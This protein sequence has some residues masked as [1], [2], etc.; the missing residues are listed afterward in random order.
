MY[1]PN[2]QGFFR[3]TITNQV[4]LS[5]MSGHWIIEGQTTTAQMIYV[6][7]LCTIFHVKFFLFHYLFPSVPSNRTSDNCKKTFYR[8]CN[9]FR[10]AKIIRELQFGDTWLQTYF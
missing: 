3:Q 4:R 5:K 6:K 1:S 8:L 9:L 10:Y 7:D 2:Y